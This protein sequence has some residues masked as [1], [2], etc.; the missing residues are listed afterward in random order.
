[1]PVDPISSVGSGAGVGEL[2]AQAAGTGRA[3]QGGGFGDM[4]VDQLQNLEEIQQDANREALALA[5]GQSDDVSSVVLAVERAALSI[6]LAAQIR[7]RGVEAYHEIWRLQ[8]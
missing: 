4:L 7:N 1:M 5:T 2:G 3:S 6:Q 8:V